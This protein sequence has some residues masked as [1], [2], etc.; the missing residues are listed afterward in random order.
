MAAERNRLTRIDDNFDSY[1]QVIKEIA[2]S[3][4]CTAITLT[5]HRW[6]SWVHMKLV[7]TVRFKIM[8]TLAV[9]ES[10]CH[11]PYGGPHGTLFL[12]GK[13]CTVVDG[14][15]QIHFWCNTFDIWGLSIENVP[16]N[17][18]VV[19]PK[20]NKIPSSFFI[21]PLSEL[22][23]VCSESRFLFLLL[24]HAAAAVGCCMHVIGTHGAFQC[25]LEFGEYS[26][27]PI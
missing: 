19:Y 10:R 15:R 22:H 18:V 17:I 5:T 8:L 20:D 24:V 2:V 26:G 21:I 3:L 13:N 11:V 23:R 1:P 7:G 12:G 27:L 4:K 25:K 16:V 14:E 6:L 9:I